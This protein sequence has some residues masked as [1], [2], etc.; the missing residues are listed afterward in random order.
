MKKNIHPQWYPNAQVI[1]ACGNVFTIGSTTPEIHTEVCSRCHPFYTG[2]QRFIDTLGRVEKFQ[3]KV[4]F[5]Q[6]HAPEIS[7][8]KAK[9]ERLKKEEAPKSFRDFKAMLSQQKQG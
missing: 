9:K 5:A 1:C 3:Q 7:A 8:K 2:Q 6:E 4:K